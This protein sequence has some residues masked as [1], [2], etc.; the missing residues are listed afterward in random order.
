MRI[1][2]QL[3]CGLVL[4]FALAAWFVLEIFVEEIKPGVRSATE[5]T[6]VDMAQLLAPLALD[7]LQEGRMEDGRLAGAFARLNQSPINAL[8]DGHLKQQAEYR[9]YVADAQGK[10]VYDSSGQD[11]GKDYS[12]WN[13]VYRTL[14][15]E[16]GARSTR[17]DPDDPASSVMHVAAP[18][19]SGEQI[20]GSLTVAKP[21]RTLLPMI[22]RSERQ[23]LQGAAVLLCLALLIGALLVWWLTRAI[24]KLVHYA[25][26]VSQDQPASLPRLHSP[27]LDRLGRS[28]ETMRRQLDGKSYI[29]GYVHSLTHEL[30]S[31]LA[32]IRGAGEILTEAPPPEV[33]QRFIGNIN[34][35][36]ARMQRLIERMLQLARLESG[37]GLDRQAISPARLGRRTLDARQIVAERRQ[38]SLQ[39]ELGEAPKQRWDPLLVEQ[40]LGNLLDNALDFSPLG[41]RVWL[42]GEMSADGYCFRVRDQGPGIP[43][44]ALPRI[45]ERFYSLPRPDKGKSS[46]LGLSFAAEVARQ[47]GGQ[48]TLGNLPEGGVLAELWL[49]AG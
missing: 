10:V 12:R 28:L 4:I 34:L 45:F 25:D 43:D 15:G 39:A 24:G 36:T 44:Y 9:I 23:L 5:D 2:L 18:L 13:D 33:A 3:L 38:I 42:S 37:Q 35:E 6:L 20:L 46:G 32:A 49:P 7:D 21:N 11:L 27:E 19:R 41:G 26:A 16:Y 47:H 31:P 48:L 17:S 22:E 1:G 40:A 29:E 30:K 14:R 8:I